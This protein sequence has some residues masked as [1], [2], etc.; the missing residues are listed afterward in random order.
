M[1]NKEFRKL[2]DIIQSE[3]NVLKEAIETKRLQPLNQEDQESVEERDE[4][5]D[6]LSLLEADTFG[7][8][9]YKIEQEPQIDQGTVG[10]DQIIA[11]SKND[12]KLKNKLL[13]MIT[14]KNMTDF[15]SY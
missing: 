5:N 14:L 2:F 3:G 15:F 7:N 12:V 9:F 4:E 8:A 1:A 11:V 6:K 13:T 10:E